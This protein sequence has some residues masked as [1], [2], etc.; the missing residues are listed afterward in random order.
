MHKNRRIKDGFN[1]TAYEV[2][3]STP[4]PRLRRLLLADM[5][6]NDKIAEILSKWETPS[7]NGLSLAVSPI[8]D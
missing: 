7:L 2:L 5:D 1:Y 8:T 3:A 6:I 4:F